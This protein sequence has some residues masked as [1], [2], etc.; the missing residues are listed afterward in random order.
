VSV[1][2]HTEAEESS[3]DEEGEGEG[4]EDREEDSGTKQKQIFIQELLLASLSL[5]NSLDEQD[6]CQS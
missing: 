2:C 6:G 1:T 5:G 4:E 3:D